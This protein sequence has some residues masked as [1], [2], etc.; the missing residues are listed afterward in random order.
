MESNNPTNS[1]GF[2][3]SRLR[4]KPST[5]T[6]LLVITFVMCYPFGYYLSLSCGWEN[7]PIEWV[8]VAVL[9]AGY[10]I[11]L[12]NGFYRTGEVLERKLWLWSSPVWLLLIGR[13][14]SWGRVFYPVAITEKGPQFL[15]HQEIWFGS[16]VYPVLSFIVIVMFAGILYH[17]LFIV[18]A[19]WLKNKPKPMVVI[20]L[21]VFS[22]LLSTA[23]EKH[24]FG[25]LMGYYQVFE[26]LYE[27]LAYVCLM[28]IAVLWGRSMDNRKRRC[29]FLR[30]GWS[31]HSFTKSAKN[32]RE[33]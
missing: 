10:L 11:S 28:D 16:Y 32:L 20:A 18:A 22:V 26:E 21:L 27:L 29:I 17:K 1:F 25:S 13:E 3:T 23:M 2:Y 6:I 15:A 12:A 31:L 19:Q 14:L 5:S 9:F 24:M 33:I 8:Q 7:G 4:W 30:D